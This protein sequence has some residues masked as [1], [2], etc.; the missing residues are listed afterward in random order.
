MFKLLSYNRRQANGRKP[1][2]S[3]LAIVSTALC[4][5]VLMSS[6]ASAN[7]V[8]TYE[9]TAGDYRIIAGDGGHV[10]EM[11]GFGYLAAPGNP[12]LPSKN[13]L[14]ALPPGSRVRAVEV[15]TA[16]GTPLAETY[17]ILPSPP[18]MP[19]LDPRQHSEVVERLQN[20]WKTNNEITYSR[21]QVYPDK[22]GKLKASG[23]FR[24]Y[25]Y[26]SVSFCPFS[27]YPQS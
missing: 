18:I 3:F 24:K 5:A 22:R 4:M 9:V 25:S 15:S 7:E 2:I 8:A 13:F 16:A 1:L 21:D 26:A 6:S 11:E 10:I 12:K 27:Y 20:E 14:I 23:T 19:V 17:S